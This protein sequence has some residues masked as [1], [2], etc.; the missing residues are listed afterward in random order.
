MSEGHFQRMAFA[1]DCDRTL[2][3]PELIPDPE[4][5]EAIQ[6]LRAKGVRCIL[7]TG[8]SRH[9]LAK[10]AGIATGFDAYAL[11]GGAR[12][13]TWDRLDETS[14]VKEALA[15]ADRAQ[16]AGIVIERREA[17][18]SVSRADLDAVR[19][20]VGECSLQQ[21]IDRVDVLPPRM[22]KGVGLDGA[23]GCLGN[24][25]LHVIAIGDAE[26]DLPM[27]HRA[28]VALGV[29]NCVPQ[30]AAAVDEV[31]SAPGPAAV[32]DASRRILQGE[33]VPPT[34]PTS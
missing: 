24:R 16:A 1:V 18:F 9:D 20:L 19:A 25:G 26:N 4:A 22:D 3:G 31:L 23:L 6:S 7:V 17:S 33:W 34:P 8:R 14:N 15:A 2:T 21:N 29:A 12:W 11:E 5:L 30:V 27:F 32:I 13:G 28:H 10:F